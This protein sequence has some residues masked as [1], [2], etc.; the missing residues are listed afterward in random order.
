MFNIKKNVT[1]LLAYLIAAIFIYNCNSIWSTVPSLRRLINIS[2]VILICISFIYILLS[3]NSQSRNNILK[4]GEITLGILIYLLVYCLFT[5]TPDKVI[6][7]GIVVILF[8]WM[9]GINNNKTV[10]PI[11]LKY[12]NLMVIIAGISLIFWLF[13]SLLHLIFPNGYI[14]SN[15][16]A[17]NGIALPVPNY[18]NL[19]FEAQNMNSN[20]NN[21]PRNTAIFTEAPMSSLNFSL[22][23]LIEIFFTSSLNKWSKLQK[24][25]LI[26]ALITTISTT[27]Y[28]FLIFIFCI[29]LF[30]SKKIDTH[31]NLILIILPI[32]VII[33]SLLIITLLNQKFNLDS[34]S[35]SIRLDDYKVGLAAWIDHP[36]FGIGIQNS[37]LLI[38]YMGNWRT[39]NTGFSNSLMDLL[40][41]GGLY[42]TV[43]YFLCFGRGIFINIHIKNWNKFWFTILTLY[44]FILIIFTYSYILIFILIWFA[45]LTPKSNYEELQCIH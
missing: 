23:L 11:L 34:G 1:N 7:I 30:Q 16:S 44:L 42:L 39:F 13:G 40:S 35:S 38:Q 31:R 14:L 8:I 10:P 22:A 6:R 28:L 15:W 37:N 24:S 3:L 43:G 20:F 5:P 36:L 41:G 17:F 12:K 19:Y 4:L 26:L 21:F 2:Y 32:I 45:F 18:H 33:G 27:G 9:V 25:I 29:R